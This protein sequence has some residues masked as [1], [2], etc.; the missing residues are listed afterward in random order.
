MIHRISSKI[1]GAMASQSIID[2]TRINVYIY[3]V[4]LLLSSA[5]GVFALIVVSACAGEYWLWIPY[6]AG[7]IPLRLLGGGYHAKSH[8]GCLII[9]T[10]AYAVYLFVYSCISEVSLYLY[11]LSFFTL[12]IILLLSPVEA[13]NKP[14]TEDT[15]QKNRV[16]SIR[17][18]LLNILLLVIANVLHMENQKW[19][20]SYFT[21]YGLA[22]LSM[23]V[24]VVINL[25][26]RREKK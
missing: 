5:F 6:L 12:G 17:L 15:R 1:S 22:G 8:R 21:G 9:F 25:M 26:K 11:T 3:G 23:T 13:N 16:C 10:S 7:F 20:V 4:E 2:S 14:L 18:A 19:I 24:A